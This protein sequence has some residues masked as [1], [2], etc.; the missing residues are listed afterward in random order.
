MRTD[1]E[2]IEYDD[3]VMGELDFEPTKEE[4]ESIE[5]NEILKVHEGKL[6][7]IKIEKTEEIKQEISEAQTLEDLKTAINKLI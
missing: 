7:A 4:R 3:R 5:K 6:T 2:P 1:G